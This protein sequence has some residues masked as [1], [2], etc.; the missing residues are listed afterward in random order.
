MTS[1]EKDVDAAK[2]NATKTIKAFLKGFLKQAQ[3]P[4]KR[5]KV[6]ADTSKE[7]TK[8][9]SPTEKKIGDKTKPFDF[10]NYS[11]RDFSI[12]GKV[13]FVS[14]GEVTKQGDYKQKDCR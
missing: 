3:T 9:G 10:V 4:P 8:M 6:A 7:T 13:A 12:T 1:Q 11:S 5:Q 2:S 14:M